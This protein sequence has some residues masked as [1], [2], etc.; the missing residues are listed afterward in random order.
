MTLASKTGPEVASLRRRIVAGTL[1]LLSVVTVFGVWLM[2]LIWRAKRRGGDDDPGSHGTGTAPRLRRVAHF[3]QSK[4]VRRGLWVTS[5]LGTVALRNLRSFGARMAGIQVVDAQSGGPV[6]IRS[7]VIGAAVDGAWRRLVIG[8]LMAPLKA[9]A[10]E[11]RAR[12]EALEPQLREL[13]RPHAGDLAEQSKIREEFY[14]ANGIRN[15]DEANLL[16]GVVG[17]VLMPLTALLSRRRQT[18][19][20]RLAGTLVIRSH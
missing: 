5:L 11:S 6:S 2:T 4:P 1:D 17:D 7:A 12:R 3:A 15:A 13:L 8:Q 19:Q 9:R 20:Q 14:N 10:N 16:W 18:I